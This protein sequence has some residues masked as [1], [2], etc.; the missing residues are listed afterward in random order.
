MTIKIKDID[1]TPKFGI[2][3]MERAIKAEMPDDNNILNIATPKLLFHACAYADE[4]NEIEPRIKYFDVVDFID[5]NG[6]QCD[7]IKA[8]QL[9]L[10][11]SMRVHMPDA[12]SK[13]AIENVIKALTPDDKKKVLKSGAKTGKKT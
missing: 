5:E 9:D 8:F 1:Y 12:E 10:F 4:R 13:E 2:G 3:F 11:K 7:E 6:S